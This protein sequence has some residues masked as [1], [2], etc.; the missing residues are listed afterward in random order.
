MRSP[1][2]SAP[3]ASPLVSQLKLSVLNLATNAAIEACER[4]WV[5]DAAVRA[6]MRGL[7]QQRLDD[8]CADQPEV[9][10]ARL[11]A[12]VEELRA[13]PIAVDT[14]AANEQ[15]YEVPAEFFHLHLGPRKK[16]S[17]AWYETGAET[18]AEAEVAM[19]EQYAARAGLADGQRILELGC[20]WGSMSLWMAQR[21]PQSQVVGVSNSHGQRAYIEQRARELS[22][23]NLK[24]ITA[25]IVDFDFPCEGVEAGFDRVISI[26]MFEHMKNYQGLFRKISSWMNTGARMFVHVFA[27]K[28]LAYH[29]VVKDKTDWMSQYFFTGGI[30]PSADLFLHYQDDLKVVQRWWINGQHYEK[31][32]NHWL[33]NMDAAR[34]DIMPVFEKAYG[35]AQAKIWF[36]RWRM[37][38]MAVAELFGYNLGR[39]W[40]V[41]HYLFEKRS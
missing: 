2:S 7:I 22:L 30:M 32:A 6:A 26:E 11:S 21:Y 39:E 41:G 16:Y 8:E 3:V 13:S 4:G 35:A 17:C 29:F 36:Q 27:H 37:F 34:K 25:N 12:L 10:R 33:A 18:L 20:G 5:P 14:D 38:Y 31:T 15:H 28:E 40:G 1:T 19:F 23:T 24:I 9:A